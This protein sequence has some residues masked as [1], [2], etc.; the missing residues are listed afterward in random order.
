MCRHSL[1]MGSLLELPPDESEWKEPVEEV[2]PIK[3][4]KID[5]LVKY[6]KAF[7]K[8]DK[9]LVF[10][11]FTTFLDHVAASLKEH[12]IHF[13]R[14]DGSMSAKQASVLRKMDMMLYL[15]GRLIFWFPSDKR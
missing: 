8:T 15:S 9:T 10:S 6:L 13:V 14:F 7:D 11:Q 4:A 5:E 12:G 3:S 2:K 1:T